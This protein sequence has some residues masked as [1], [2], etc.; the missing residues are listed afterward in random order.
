M[1]QCGESQP[2]GVKRSLVHGSSVA[3]TAAWV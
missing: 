1:N 3:G 2:A